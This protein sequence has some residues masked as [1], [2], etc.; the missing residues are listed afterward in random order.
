MNCQHVHELLPR[1]TDERLA[2]DEV[3]LVR[4]H[5]GACAG[6]AA[7]ARASERTDAIIA[8]AVSDHPF[9]DEAVEKLLLQLPIRASAQRMHGRPTRGAGLGLGAAAAAAL[10][11]AGGLFLLPERRTGTGEQVAE[12]PVVGKATGVMRKGSGE[13]FERLAPGT[14]VRAG[15]LLVAVETPAR[16][17]LEGG[18]KVDLHADTELSLRQDA[19][20]GLTVAL[21]VAGG[22]VLCEVSK[23][24]T[25]FRVSARGVE[26]EVLG[27]RFLVHQGAKVSRVVVH[28]GLVRVSAHGESR[29]LGPDEAAEVR[30]E[31]R[32]LELLK[33]TALQYGAWHPAVAEEARAAAAKGS[34]GVAVPPAPVSTTT[35]P[36]GPIDPTVD[37]PVIPPGGDGQLPGK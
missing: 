3:A 9:G 6:C 30:P 27:T 24:T 28:R 26:A 20:G 16:I 13:G 37:M 17:E 5:L 18:T 29:R 2:Q 1:L 31:V 23:R 34:P 22:E 8:A 35:P 36:S 32:G 10:L 15:E 25:P 19:D 4:A 14:P 12:A 33:V 11:V 21:G 7:E